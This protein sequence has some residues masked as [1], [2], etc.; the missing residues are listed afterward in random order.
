MAD[1]RVAAMPIAECG[2]RLVDVR[3]NRLLTR[4]L[5][6]IMRMDEFQGPDALPL[7]SRWRLRVQDT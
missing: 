3:R 7:S 4:S 5:R 1:P 2:E 6:Q